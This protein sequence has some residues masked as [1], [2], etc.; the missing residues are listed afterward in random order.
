MVQGLLERMFNAE[1]IDSWFENVGEVQY[2]RKILF[3][4]L[5]S[6][7]LQV[8]CRVKSNVYSAYLDSDIDATRQAVYDKLKN[9]ETKTSQEI[10]RY[11]ATESEKIIREIKGTQ[12][13]LLPG[14]RIKFLDG[15]C[16]EASE[17]RLKVLRETKAG[18]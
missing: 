1:K 16:I 5:V 18:A 3:S 11:I 13:A 2:T 8:V 4:S 14:L 12:P 15:N 17:H 9:T 6:I 7:M 10:V